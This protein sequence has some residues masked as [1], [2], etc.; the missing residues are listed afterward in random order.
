MLI[1]YLFLLGSFGLVNELVNEL[2][3]TVYEP[4]E[5]VVVKPVNDGKGDN[6]YNEGRVPPRMH[7]QAQYRVDDRYDQ[8]CEKR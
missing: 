1:E 7:Q 3:F 2:Y 5:S 8:R 6:E 4:L